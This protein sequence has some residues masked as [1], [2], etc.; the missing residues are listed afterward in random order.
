[1][2]V[3]SSFFIVI[4][5]SVLVS[6]A[7]ET[8]AKDQRFSTGIDAV[9][10]TD[11]GRRL[12]SGK[13]CKGS[14]RLGSKHRRAKSTNGGSSF[15]CPKDDWICECI[16]YFFGL[17]QQSRRRLGEAECMDSEYDTQFSMF[18]EKALE[19]LQESGLFTDSQKII[20]SCV[21]AMT[22][23][24]ISSCQ[25]M[26][27]GQFFLDKGLDHWLD[28]GNDF[29]TVISDIECEA[30]AG[31]RRLTEDSCVEELKG[32]IVEFFNPEGEEGYPMVMSNSVITLLPFVPVSFMLNGGAPTEDESAAQ[33][34]SQP[35]QMPTP[36]II[37]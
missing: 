16:S 6:L 28:V 27:I 11:G 34:S 1:M 19:G 12:K 31:E 33:C 18:R 9:H 20:L 37:D 21:S 4:I 30:D 22:P 3:R 13:S 8:A 29:A 35:S 25:F 5:A 10:F 17:L 36:T 7:T 2:F 26:E 14:R 32:K 15:C 24:F 23:M